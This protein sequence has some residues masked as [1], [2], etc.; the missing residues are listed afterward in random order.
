MAT[1]KRRRRQ[2]DAD[3]ERAIMVLADSH[4]PT[5]I[6]REL[7]RRVGKDRTPALRTVQR[8]IADVT[9]KDALPWQLRDADPD[10]AALLLPV[11]AAAIER[12][13]G[14]VRQVTRGH[15]E[16]I[17]RLR[18]ASPEMPLYTAFA[19]AR[20]YVAQVERGLPT[21]MF[22]ELLAFAPWTHPERYTTA[23]RRGWVTV[24]SPRLLDDLGLLEDQSHG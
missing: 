18:R 13:E 3:M 20:I 23:T 14:R 1:V 15:A 9:P 12:T 2:I 6:H 4:T 17:V 21:T 19:L 8:V 10:D 11:L 7:E 16:W 5:Q 22:D 24:F